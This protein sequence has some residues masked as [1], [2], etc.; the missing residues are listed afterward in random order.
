MTFTIYTF[1]N[2][3]MLF[4]VFTSIALMVGAGYESLIRFA[5]IALVFGALA[6]VIGRGHV[7]WQLLG[8][9]LVILAVTVQIRA[10][11]LVQDLVNPGVPTRTVANIPLAV[12][13]PAYVVSESSF[14]LLTL[15]ET[16]FALTVPTEYQV[17]NSTMGRGFYDFQKLLGAQLP[18]S[19]LQRNLT[20]YLKECVIPAVQ[21]GDLT[22]TA[23]FD[24]QDLL[25]AINV[26]G[27]LLVLRPYVGGVRVAP[28]SC[29]TA[30][31]TYIS[32]KMVPGGDPAY[33]LA[34][35]Q[36]RRALG[37]QDVALAEET[38][39]T[40]A[41]TRIM[42]TGQSARAAI[43]NVIIRE[44]WQS[45]EEL[46]NQRGNDPAAAVA[47][48][49]KQLGEDLKSQAFANSIMN[50]RFLPLLR[51]M[52]ES[53]VYLLTPFALVLAF[54]PS[55]F[56]AIRGTVMAYAWL[57]LWA[58]LYAVVNYLVYAY[59]TAQLASLVSP[60]VGI[61]YANYVDFYDIL[62]Q[63]NSFSSSIAW[64]VPSMAAFMTYGLGAA[65]ST[66]SQGGQGY[67]TAAYQ[68][69]SAMSH[70]QLRYVSPDRHLEYEDQMSI[71]AS[72]HEY[73]EPV[74]RQSSGMMMMNQTG[75]QDIQYSDGSTTTIGTTG[76]MTHH[77]PD[78]YYSQDRDGH[79]MSGVWRQ[80]VHDEA[81]GQT[82]SMQR[83]VLGAE[84]R[85]RGAYEDGDGVQHH[86]ERMD[87]QYD[88][89]SV[90]REESWSAYG[91]Q[92][93]VTTQG[94]GS[95][96]HQTDGYV[97]TAPVG[98][99]GHVMGSPRQ[100]RERNTFLQAA[101]TADNPN[102]QW[103]HQY[104][105][106]TGGHD[107]AEHYVTT[108]DTGGAAPGNQ[109]Y[110][111]R[112]SGGS[113]TSNVSDHSTYNGLSVSR[114]QGKEGNV[115]SLSGTVP[116]TFIDKNGDRHETSAV[117]TAS[118]ISLDDHGHPVDGFTGSAVTNEDGFHGVHQGTVSRNAD[119]G[120]WEMQETD[121]QYFSRLG[122]QSSGSEMIV[123]AENGQ[124]GYALKS[125]NI[126]HDGD[127][128]DPNH[129]WHYEGQIKDRATGEA[130]N[131][132][133]H[134]D[135]KDLALS[136]MAR[137]SKQHIVSGDGSQ[138][139][140]TGNPSS[141]EG[142]QYSKS[143][144]LSGY[145]PT[146][147]DP[148]GKKLYEPVSGQMVEKGIVRA[149]GDG[150]LTFLPND[151]KLSATTTQGAFSVSAEQ[152]MVP[153]SQ[154]FRKSGMQTAVRTDQG[155]DSGSTSVTVPVGDEHPVNVIL[156]V[157]GRVGNQLIFDQTRV[158]QDGTRASERKVL[159]PVSMGKAHSVI[160]GG[161]DLDVVAN[162]HGQKGR[163]TG[164]ESNDG[165]MVQSRFDALATDEFA[166][167]G[168]A[169][170]S[171]SSNSGELLHESG[172]SGENFVSQYNNREEHLAGTTL[173]TMGLV[174]DTYEKMGGK[175]T[176]GDDP[177]FR[178]IAYGLETGRLTADAAQRMLRLRYSIQRSRGGKVN[179]SAP[180]EPYDQGH[181][182]DM[183]R[184]GFEAM[185]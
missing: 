93:S 130:F 185:K 84:I 152:M 82:I 120:R 162:Q 27:G 78:G 40:T 174:R 47:L 172:V 156:P 178:G 31:T 101:P 150:E 175:V 133:M 184:H 57:L 51:T 121:A 5:M 32:P 36:L 64:G 9:A 151:S 73:H 123:G 147:V 173:D 102:P 7:P 62:N 49:G 94:D 169:T 176:P 139:M 74:L 55:M 142:A 122:G 19:N 128:S 98:A 109:D 180:E 6:Y 1:G 157:D 103:E 92:H 111:R 163:F 145:F 54:T 83:E 46:I 97:V 105:E 16:A 45:A 146:G 112:V 12:A 138:I 88:G 96:V 95:Q 81:S 71:D 11:V 114:E 107:G 125:G 164:K 137:G 53:A 63:L 14:Q 144:A 129:A 68:E 23:V 115:G 168:F 149:S 104:G 127:L 99:D 80:D 41:L 34:M 26:T 153:G 166:K 171:R 17:L 8:G 183:M 170:Q 117:L 177:Y 135:G 85:S 29:T 119:S 181:S 159:D 50:A 38:P 124:G 66:L 179:K 154:V 61:T 39:V 18:D 75:T 167:R 15:A 65:V 72:G 67:Q 126:R 140:I 116:M 118:G 90:Y 21:R 86:V 131:G 158:G 35:Q 165:Q 59:G 91:V 3:N 161:T 33:D 56:S 110:V 52:A 155:N 134:F 160:Q 30:Y 141:P 42:G 58:P 24:A 22:T 13:F 136:D 143:G 25:A 10:T 77:G 48:L 87:N 79:Y 60:G 100:F 69:G 2:G 44:R 106:L 43:N 108:M 148:S 182:Q 89:Q 70:G 113:R 132:S 20:E 28:V 37:V 4:D 76:T